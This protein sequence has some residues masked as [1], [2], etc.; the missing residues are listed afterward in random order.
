M[1][2]EKIILYFQSFNIHARNF[3]Q[4]RDE[5]GLF[6]KQCGCLT[7]VDNNKTI[8]RKVSS[9]IKRLNAYQKLVAKKLIHVRAKHVCSGCVK[10]NVISEFE[11][12]P[13]T[14]SQINLSIFFVCFW[15]K[16]S[17]RTFGKSTSWFAL[18]FQ[19]YFQITF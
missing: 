9:S 18:P 11:T 16:S 13:D 1:K 8:L 7:H 15:N 4:H 6:K 5:G 2:I 12:L 14:E 17:H 3:G 10:Q 19:V